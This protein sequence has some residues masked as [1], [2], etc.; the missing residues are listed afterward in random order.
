MTGSLKS[1]ET[2]RM[3]D[4]AKAENENSEDL[5]LSEREGEMP[6]GKVSIT[7]FR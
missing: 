1:N 3:L 2:I 7:D 6:Q 4:Q 5:I